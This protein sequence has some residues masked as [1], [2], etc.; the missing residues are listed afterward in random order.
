MILKLIVV[1]YISGNF[2]IKLGTTIQQ[3][4][5]IMFILSGHWKSCITVRILVLFSTTMLMN[6]MVVIIWKSSA[7]RRSDW[8]NGVSKVGGLEINTKYKT[9]MIEIQTENSIS[10]I[11]INTKHSTPKIEIKIENSTPKIEINTKSSTRKKR[12]VTAWCCNGHER[13]PRL[14]NLMFIYASL[15]GIAEQNDMIPIG[16]ETMQLRKVFKI[17]LIDL[18]PTGAV[19]SG[20]MSV[21]YREAKPMTH[22]PKLFHL[23]RSYDAVVNGFLANQE[24]FK[25][26]NDKVRMEFRFQNTIQEEANG[27]LKN[28]TLGFEGTQFVLVGI[29]ARRGDYLDASVTYWGFT[30]AP[31]E[32]Y[33]QA[34]TYFRRLFNNVHFVVCSD[35]IKWARDH[36]KGGD[37]IFSENHSHYVDMAILS[38]CDHVIMSVGTYGWWAAWLA[39]GMVVY[40]DKWAEPNSALDKDLDKATYFPSNWIP[41]V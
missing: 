36:L 23:N 11:D 5:T 16:L 12:T 21:D 17:S 6:V 7:A 39:N 22:N 19:L 8:R 13:E 29:H 2:K 9:P 15:L 3:L 32:Y 30:T 18:I 20:N 37:V 33:E 25:L 40:Y 28:A 10:K 26:S 34:M 4:N 1:I 38:S 27:F 31:A 14:G 35:D 41:M 24:Y